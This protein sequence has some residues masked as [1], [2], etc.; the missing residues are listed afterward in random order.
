MK[1]WNRVAHPGNNLNPS[2]FRDWKL[3]QATASSRP[4]PR[5]T[6]LSVTTLGAFMSALDSNIVT[7]ALPNISKDLSA[8]YSLLGWVLAGYVLAVAALVLQAGKLGDN[9]GKKRIYLIGF[10]I[11]GVSSALCGLSPS[12]YLLIAFRIV[13]GTGASV[14]LATGIPMI[15]ASFPPKERGSAVGINSVAWAVGAVAG[16]V[17]GGTLTSIDWRLI[18]YVNVP[19]AA[20]A[21]LVGRARIPGWLDTRNPNAGRLNLPNATVLGI[22]IGLVMLWLTLLDVRLAVLAAFGIAAFSVVEWRSRNPILSRELLRNRGF[23]FSAIGLGIMM[24]S[25][26]GVVF[27]MSFYFQSVA[28]FTP[29]AAGIWVAPLP[30]M[31]GIANPLSGRLFDRFRLPAIMAILGALLVSG[32]IFLLSAAINTRSPGLTITVLL[33]LIGVAGGFV[34]SPSIS[35]AIAFARSEMRGVANGTAFTLIYVGFATSIALVVSVSTA[36]LPAA[37]SA[38]IHSGSV[39]GLSASSAMLFDQGLVSSLV[40]LGI[41]G[42]LGVPFLFLVLREQA[43][44][45][46]TYT[47]IQP[48]S[49]SAAS[50]VG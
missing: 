4:L 44:Q 9:Y 17:L 38:Q 50:T 3:T 8:G 39:T 11:F 26:F 13:Q 14:M 24:T 29:L 31:L 21:I 43:K 49:A 7:I 2:H 33:A 37:L 27:L 47:E 36:S 18:F 23:V 40:A 16:P 10:A 6:I 28:G 15:F 30:A 35:S 12:V 42:L 1:L 46:R 22:A 19:V 48:D 5:W 25:F 34:W 20:V 32:S 45:H 41:V